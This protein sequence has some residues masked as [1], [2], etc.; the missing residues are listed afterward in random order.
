MKSLLVNVLDTGLYCRSVV[1][2]IVNCTGHCKE[3]KN[4]D[5]PYIENL[6]LPIIKDLKKRN[7]EGKSNAGIVDLLLFDG[8]TNV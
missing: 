5:S 7:P 1:L 2:D 6:F 4:K 8:A 3:G